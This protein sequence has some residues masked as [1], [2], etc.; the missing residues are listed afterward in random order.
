VTLTTGAEE[1]DNK[2]SNKLRVR[3]RRSF[4]E[5]GISQR[6]QE[7]LARIGFEKPTPVQAG[8]I[9]L[10]MAGHDLIGQARTGTGKT[11]AFGIP[12][13]DRL[14]ARFENRDNSTEESAGGQSAKPD[15]GSRS[16]RAPKDSGKRSRYPTALVL[17]P[18]RELC[19]QVHHELARLADD[20]TINEVPDSGSEQPRSV[21][22]RTAIDN[23]TVR[24]V[25]V[26][27]GK[28][29][30]WQINRLADGCD[31]VVGTPGRIIDHLQRGTFNPDHLE[32]VV[33]D[34]A[35]RMLDI[36]FRPAI[37]K[38][39]R[40]VPANR[41]MLLLS[42][43][44]PPPILNLA[45]RYMRG[46][47]LANFSPK[48]ISVETIDQYYLT[49]RE[50][51]KVD[52]LEQ[53]LT[54]QTPSQAIIFCRTRLGTERL[55][56]KLLKTKDFADAKAI[57]GD[58]SQ[59]ARDRVMASFRA[60]ET[61]ILVA[62]DVVGR[63][64]DVSH[65]S[66]IINFDIPELSDDYVHRV[67]RTGRMGR[68]GVAFTLVTPMQKSELVQIERRIAKELIPFQLEGHD[69][70]DIKEQTPVKRRVRR[71]RRGL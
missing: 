42:A 65:V 62:T 3:Q 50:N 67:G 15:S 44:L 61:K 40:R 7:I 10:V 63:G 60:G 16:S 20:D 51:D 24:S 43:T 33:L 39:L 4:A 49:V 41:Q 66:H 13:I 59:P 38:I 19:L 29:M 57:H 9:P 64:I 25:P 68:E 22:K 46:A 12:I 21:R 47:K 11:A 32:T 17:V 26:Y 2:P 23:N 27:G 1:A 70:T 71:Y 18:T 69:T 5:L 56:R 55:Y 37:E 14:E 48:N 30:K 52:V 45:R 54:H 58:M 35:D 6:R 8:L 31:I 53:L 36:G 34:E 28:S